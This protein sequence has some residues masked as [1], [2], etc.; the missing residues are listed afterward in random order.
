M[1][2][3]N[4]KLKLKVLS[5]HFGEPVTV[6]R[7]AEYPSLF[8][9]DRMITQGGSEVAARIDQLIRENGLTFDME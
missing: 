4:R 7:I 3:P 1:K 2:K 6:K 5:D 8:I 9:G